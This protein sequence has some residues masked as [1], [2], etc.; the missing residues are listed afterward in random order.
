MLGVVCMTVMAESAPTREL[1]LAASCMVIVPVFV[2][3]VAD[4]DVNERAII[5]HKHA[6][7]FIGGDET[8][9]LAGVIPEV[10]GGDA[11]RVLGNGL[12]VCIVREDAD[13][14]LRSILTHAPRGATGQ[15]D[16]LV[17]RI[18]RLQSMIEPEAQVVARDSVGG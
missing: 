16:V 10:C 15:Q 12:H 4:G 5:L 3:V 7:F 17:S 13:V 6:A 14:R 11:E 18:G 9:G 8:G 1:A 2:C